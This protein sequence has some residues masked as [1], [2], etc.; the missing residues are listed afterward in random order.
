MKTEYRSIQ[1]QIRRV[2]I[3]GHI[4]KSNFWSLLVTLTNFCSS[5]NLRRK[6]RLQQHLLFQHQLPKHIQ[7]GFLVH[8]HHRGLPRQLLSSG[9][10]ASLLIQSADSFGDFIGPNRLSEFHI[11]AAWRQREL[12]G[13]L[14]GGDRIRRKCSGHLR[15]KL[16]AAHLRDICGQQQHHHHHFHVIKRRS[17]AQL[18]FSCHSNC[19]RLSHSGWVDTDSF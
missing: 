4:E 18:Q 6:L 8:F 19:L 14:H 16:R 7:R 3:A 12:R 10:L 11:S 2:G 13:W 9:W 1:F 17:S 5:A 15:R